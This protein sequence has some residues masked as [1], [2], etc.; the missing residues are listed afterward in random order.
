MAKR[1]A[2]PPE[3]DSEEEEYY[4]DDLEDGSDEDEDGEAAAGGG[5]DFDEEEDDD[6]ELD[7]EMAALESVRN[8]RGMGRSDRPLVNNEAGLDASIQDFGWTH[9]AKWIDHMVVAGAKDAPPVAD[10]NDDLARETHFYE[11]ALGSANEAIRRLKELG[12]PVKR[13]HD[14]YAEM[15]KSDEHMKRVRAELIFE[16]T[17]QETREE[18]RKAREQKRYGKQVQ[19]EKL[20]E[21]TLK[22]KESIKNLDKWRKQRKQNNYSEEG[23]KAPEGFEDGFRSRDSPKG[24]KR[25]T[26]ETRQKREFKNEKFGFGGRKRLKKQNDKESARDMSNFKPSNFDRDFK[27]G[28]GWGSLGS[29]GKGGRGGRGGGRSPGGGGGGRGRR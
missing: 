6:D 10:V 3:E 29:K 9:K 8:E 14:Y 15:V 28:K 27:A 20:K 2:A 24:R 25:S 26:Q 22:K 19:A 12:V 11:Q 5:R 4:E 1:K 7:A 18:R 16:Q 21:R 17:A 23:A 13:P